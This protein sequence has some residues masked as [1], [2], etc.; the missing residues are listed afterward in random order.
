[1]PD[2]AELEGLDPADLLDRE[3]AR[4][5]RYFTEL[6]ASRWHLPSRC[7]GWSI[8]DVLAHLSAVEDYF[9]ACLAG[10]VQDYIRAVAARGGTD[11]A[12]AN[13]LGVAERADRNPAQLLERWRADDAETRR[14][15]RERADGRIDTSAGDYPSRWQAFH[16]ASELAVHADDVFVPVTVEER[17]TRRDWRAR[18][19]RFVLDEYKPELAVGTE[20]GRTRVRGDG[21]DVLL[22]DDELIDGVAGRLDAASR[23]SAAERRVLNSTP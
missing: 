23:L 20:G 5:D 2:D 11:V 15:F 7:P 13:E 1:V 9:H 16:V 6:P 4:L 14:G 10:T 21:C 8:R 3:A 22:D 12:S 17:D 19:S 18:F